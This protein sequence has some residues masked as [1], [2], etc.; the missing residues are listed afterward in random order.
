MH[1]KTALNSFAFSLKDTEEQIGD[2]KI[3]IRANLTNNLA[4]K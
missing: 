2:A 3:G 4:K 1:L